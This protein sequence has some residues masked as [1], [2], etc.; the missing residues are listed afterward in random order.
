[1]A[2]CFRGRSCTATRLLP[3]T[4]PSPRPCYPRGHIPIVTG[5]VL[6]FE[7][8]RVSTRAYCPSMSSRLKNPITTQTHICAFVHLRVIPASSSSSFVRASIYAC[9]S[10][11]IFRSV[12]LQAVLN[13]VC[14][15]A[16]RSRL[17][18]FVGS[19]VAAA[20]ATGFD[21]RVV[22][23]PAPPRSNARIWSSVGCFGFG[24]AENVFFDIPLDL[25]R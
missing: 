17:R 10:P 7:R 22:S 23:C 24:A 16:G 5:D 21:A 19:S 25:F 18:R 1:M 11:T 8:L 4:T 2:G 3:R 12:A 15:L 13:R 20:F 14:K 6:V 9:S